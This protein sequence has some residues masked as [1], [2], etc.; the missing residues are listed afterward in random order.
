MTETLQRIGRAGHRPDAIALGV[1]IA[2]DRDDIVEAA[3]TKRCIADGVIE[4][5]QVPEAPLDVLAQWMVSLV[6]YE[7]RATIDDV[8]M[9]ARRAYPFRNLSRDHVV[10]CA[11]YLSGGGIGGDEAHVR[12]LGFD[13]EAIFGLGRDVCS[14][15]FEN[16]GTIPDEASVMVRVHGA[17]IGRVEEGFVNELKVGAVFVLQGRS[18]R[19]REITRSGVAA[20]P[21]AGRPTVPQWRDL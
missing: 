7:R 21:F 8:V 18:L 12:R 6:C 19:V 3:A 2:Q 16:V 4:E 13:G 17:N 11:Q 10:R 9:M 1:I 5:V 15:Y 14:A 20:E